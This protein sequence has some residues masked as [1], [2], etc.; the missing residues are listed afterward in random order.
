MKKV[1]INIKGMS[2]NSCENHVKDKLEKIG[3]KKISVSSLNGEANMS[4]DDEVS[5]ANLKKAIEE[6]GYTPLEVE[7]K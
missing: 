1:K 2:C 7:F 4:I 3:A 6:A 5:E